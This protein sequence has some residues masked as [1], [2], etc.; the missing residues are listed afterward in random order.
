MCKCVSWNC[1]VHLQLGWTILEFRFDILPGYTFRKYCIFTG[2][3]EVI[4]LPFLLSRFNSQRIKYTILK[5]TPQD[6]F[7]VMQPAP[8][9]YSRMVSL[10][11]DAPSGKQSPLGSQCCVFYRCGFHVVQSYS[12]VFSGWLAAF[13]WVFSRFILAA[14]SISQVFVF[15]FVFFFFTLPN[16]IPLGVG[17]T[18]CL[19]THS[20]AGRH[21]D[22]SQS[23]LVW[24]M[25]LQTYLCEQFSVLWAYAWKMSYCFPFYNPASIIW[26]F[27]F[28]PILSSSSLA[29]LFEHPGG[30]DVSC[31]ALIGL[32]LLT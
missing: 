9:S 25:L 4:S 11:R 7:Q 8:L 31:Y 17:P 3:S 2:R 12:L 22:C 21:W 30:H 1:W 32:G 13:T 19:Y 27:Q 18:V 10:S 6:C 5:C 16:S 26:R 28:L 23:G 24:V 15:F 20:S 14:S 29:C